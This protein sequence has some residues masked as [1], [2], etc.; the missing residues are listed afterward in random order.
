MDPSSHQLIK[1]Q[2][3]TLEQVQLLITQA[4]LSQLLMVVTQLSLLL[5]TLVNQ[6]KEVPILNPV[7]LTMLICPQPITMVQAATIMLSQ[8]TIV[9]I[10]IFKAVIMIN[11]QAIT[12]LFLMHKVV[13]M[14]TLQVISA[15]IKEMQVVTIV[16]SKTNK[17]VIMLI[18]NQAITKFNQVTTKNS[19]AFMLNSP[20]TIALF[21][22][23]NQASTALT[24]LIQAVITTPQY[25]M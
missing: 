8:V 14:L 9:H 23:D 16:L 4:L 18:L 13:I 17:V 21:M 3:Q 6:L 22:K 5:Q 12:V 20:A 7:H 2:T 1:T 10:Q 24:M 15:L 25:L 11:S 19:Q